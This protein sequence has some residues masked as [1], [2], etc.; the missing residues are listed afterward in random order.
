MR[1]AG[2][3]RKPIVISPEQGS[4]Y[5]TGPMRAIF[6]ADSKES[7]HRY[8]VS[9][10]SSGKGRT[11]TSGEVSRIQIRLRIEQERSAG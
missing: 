5:A 6:K 7:P 8:S 1:A 4:V 3:V 11:C 2:V 9:E 10:F